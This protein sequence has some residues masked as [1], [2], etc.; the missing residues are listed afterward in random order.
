MFMPDPRTVVIGAPQLLDA[1]R[2]HAGREGEVLTFG[3]HEALQALE[4]ITA[5]RPDVVTL[6]RLFAATSRGAALINRIKEDPALVATEIRIVSHDGTYSRISA[7]RVSPPQPVAE[8]PIPPPETG[9]P[10]TPA[11]IDYHGT[12]RVPRFKMVEGAEAQVDGASA[13]I[14]DLSVFGAQ[15]VS[16]STLRPQQRVRIILSDDAGVVRVNAVVAWASFEIP[17][18]TPRYRAGI[19]FT[20][21]QAAAV[22]AFCKRHQL[23]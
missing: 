15:I 10:A 19:E 2:R 8:A 17:K 9:S 13:R 4:L 16:P 11:R 1:L 6:E 22:D 12:R 21:A 18:S 14:V 3:D 7:R 5:S 20:D 23:V